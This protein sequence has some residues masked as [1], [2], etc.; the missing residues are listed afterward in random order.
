MGDRTPQFDTG[1]SGELIQGIVGG[2]KV[3][4]QLFMMLFFGHGRDAYNELV[5]TRFYLHTYMYWLVLAFLMN[6]R[7][8]HLHFV[9]LLAVLFSSSK[10]GPFPVFFYRI[11][12]IGI[13]VHRF[14]GSFVG[15]LSNL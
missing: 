5:P 9:V 6:G 2:Q 11:F 10:L 8:S 7:T 3:R 12:Q 14:S 4:E 15:T 13:F 1:T